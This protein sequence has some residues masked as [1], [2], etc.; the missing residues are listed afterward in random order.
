MDSLIKIYILILLPQLFSFL[1]CTGRGIGGPGGPNELLKDGG[2]DYT[3]PEIETGF[4]GKWVIE[5]PNVGVCAMQ[6]QLMPNDQVV[7]FDATSLGPSA[8]KLEPEGNCPL[9]PDTKNTPD[10][11]AHALAYDW[12]TKKSRTIVVCFSYLI[13]H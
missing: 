2:C 10:C 9:N 6:L 11:F 12:K 1:V 13:D 7:W 5:N 8:R 4:K 3:K